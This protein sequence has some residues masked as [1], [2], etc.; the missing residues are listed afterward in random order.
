[1]PPCLKRRS[2]AERIAV[3]HQRRRALEGED[4]LLLVADDEEAARCRARAGSGGEIVGELVEDLPL[5]LARVLRLVDQHMVDAGIELVQH[6]AGIGAFEQ[7]ARAIDQIVEIE[8]APPPT[9]PL[10]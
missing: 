9:S 2:K 10:S 7:Q 5:R 1:M 8:Q 4:R 6:P 3:E